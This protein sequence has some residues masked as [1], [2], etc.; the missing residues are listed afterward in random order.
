MVSVFYAIAKIRK[1]QSLG[2][3]NEETQNNEANE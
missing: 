2:F 3:T 1:K